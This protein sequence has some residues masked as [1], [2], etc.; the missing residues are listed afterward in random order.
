M[1]ATRARSLRRVLWSHALSRLR[2]RARAR[3]ALAAYVRDAGVGD[4]PPA[5]QPYVL[6]REAI[7][8]NRFGA[9]MLHRLRTNNATLGKYLHRGGVVQTAQCAFCRARCDESKNHF[10]LQCTAWRTQRRDWNVALEA[11]LGR[12]SARHLRTLRRQL[13]EAEYV[14]V[15]LG[16]TVPDGPSAA[17]RA[18]AEP[19]RAARAKIQEAACDG[20]GAMFRARFAELE[21]LSGGRW[22]RLRT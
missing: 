11:K 15:L 21:R 18:A 17:S 13:S 19:I 16:G 5:G 3:P 14:A 1:P 4:F 8:W 12:E 20:L 10:V 2:H 9:L 6:D 7:G 22:R